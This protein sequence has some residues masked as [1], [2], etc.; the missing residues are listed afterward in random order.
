MTS[1]GLQEIYSC[2]QTAKAVFVS[3]APKHA[4]H[5]DRLVSLRCGL[6]YPFGNCLKDT[7]EPIRFNA[8]K[9]LAP[10]E[11]IPDGTNGFGSFGAVH[12]LFQKFVARGQG[13][14]GNVQH[15][16]IVQLLKHFVRGQYSFS[17]L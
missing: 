15:T 6:G 13:A 14:A 3:E 2:G 5:A 1:K 7:L 9:N 8:S 4:E 12:Y 10:E 11:Q 16:A 17:M